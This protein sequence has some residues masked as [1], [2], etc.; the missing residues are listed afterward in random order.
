MSIPMIRRVLAGL[1]LAALLAA[2]PAQAAGLERTTGAPDLW[3][4]AWSWV[5]RV[6][7][8]EVAGSSAPR[9]STTV[10]TAKQLPGDDDSTTTNSGDPTNPDGGDK[11]MGID[12]DG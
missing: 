2:V 10:T 8:G 9:P 12:P 1:A 11:G 3:S 4:L 6:W 7:G 5:V